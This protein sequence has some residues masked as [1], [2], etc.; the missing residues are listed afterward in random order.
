[1]GK[2]SANA[3]KYFAR[4]MLLIP[5]NTYRI[6]SDAIH[7]RVFILFKLACSSCKATPSCT[8]VLVVEELQMFI[9]TKL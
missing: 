9:G 7:S 3:P 4:E 1:M 5:Q 6:Q 8:M 2:F